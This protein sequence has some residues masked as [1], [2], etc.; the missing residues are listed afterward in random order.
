MSYLFLPNMRP[1]CYGTNGYWQVL[2]TVLKI[3]WKLLH[4]W[5]T[6]G[7]GFLFFIYLFIFNLKLWPKTPNLEARKS[8]S[9]KE[10][11]TKSR[12]WVIK[13]ERNWDRLHG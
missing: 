11:K 10:F 7:F 4:V 8:F 1:K 5:T 13:L 12:L 2:N 6:I 3:V 9:Q